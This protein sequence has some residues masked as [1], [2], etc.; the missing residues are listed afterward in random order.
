V[1][2][3][4]LLEDVYGLHVAVFPHPATGLPVVAPSANS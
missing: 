2:Q 1:L 4:A 3:P